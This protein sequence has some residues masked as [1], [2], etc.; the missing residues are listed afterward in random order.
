MITPL[1][2]FIAIIISYVSAQTAVLFGGSGVVGSEVLK[3][4]L[5]HGSFED[6][7]VVGRQ[8]SF[9]KIDEIILSS[10]TNDDDDDAGKT[11]VTR[12]NLSRVEDISTYTN[13]ERADACIIALGASAPHL[14]NLQQWHSVEVDLIR[15][16]AEFCNKIQVRYISLLSAVDVEHES[17]VPFTKEEIESYGE[18]PLGW[19]KM[20]QL[21]N[22]VKGLEERAVI[23]SASDVQYIRLFQPN[24][25]VTEKPRYG[26]FDASLF[27]LHKLVDPYLPARYHSVDVRL[28][29]AKFAADAKRN[30]QEEEDNGS[31]VVAKLTYEDYVSVVGKA[32][33]ESL[34]A[35]KDEL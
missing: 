8:S 20:I 12:V 5:S 3:S 17:V 24:T 19:I 27:S 33:E 28:L 11:K 10:A 13:I 21:Y 1:L 23:E 30:L 34:V 29:G 26:W 18:G 9:K 7:I 4:L 22:R 35:T 16:I 14:D 6:L 32:F 2:F 31:Q 15:T 25:I